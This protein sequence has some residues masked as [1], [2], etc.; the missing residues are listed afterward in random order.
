MTWIMLWLH[1]QTDGRYG[2]RANLKE[3]AAELGHEDARDVFSHAQRLSDRGLIEPVALGGW[4]TLTDDGLSRVEDAL[5][6]LNAAPEPEPEPHASDLSLTI[7]IEL[8]AEL[9]RDFEEL[10]A[11]VS[12]LRDQ[13]EEIDQEDWD[14]LAAGIHSATAELRAARPIREILLRQSVRIHETVLRLSEAANDRGLDVGARL[15]SIG[16]LVLNLHSKL[17]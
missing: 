8:R 6:E 11:K 3:L 12:A 7:A 13:I 2:E 16:N 15:A 1:E 9:T 14:D 5:D 10:L 17:S 4:Y